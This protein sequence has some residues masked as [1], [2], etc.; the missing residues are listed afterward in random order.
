M[1]TSTKK[2]INDELVFQVRELT[3]YYKCEDEEGNIVNI[4][5]FLKR[6]EDLG[7]KNISFDIYKGS[8]IGLVGGKKCGKSTLLKILSGIIKPTSGKILYRETKMSSLQLR[9]MVS[10]ISKEQ[11]SSQEYNCTLF[12]N[13][14]QYACRNNKNR[15]DVVDKAEKLV[16]DFEIGEYRYKEVIKLPSAIRSKMFIIRGFLSHKPVLCF[17]QPFSYIEEPYLE[18]FDKYLRGSVLAGKT[19]IM[20]SDEI[21]NIESMCDQIISL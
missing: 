3:K 9:E 15:S 18:V 7:I 1:Q 4:I 14:I 16:N 21:V 2:N 8:I 20:S 19:I 13:I 17:D 6:K 12:E 10:Y 5:N 11:P